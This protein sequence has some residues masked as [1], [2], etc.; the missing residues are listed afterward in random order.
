MMTITFSTNLKST[1]NH[2]LVQRGLQRP[3]H[4][5]AICCEYSMSSGYKLKLKHH[6]PKKEDCR[7]YSMAQKADNHK[8]RFEGVS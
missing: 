4:S 3:G 7:Y 1:F 5:I 6:P 8:A 2:A